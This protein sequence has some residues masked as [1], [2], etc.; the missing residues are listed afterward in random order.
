MAVELR[1][2]TLGV[3]DGNDDLLA[4]TPGSECAAEIAPAAVVLF[5]RLRERVRGSDG[6]RIFFLAV[7]VEKYGQGH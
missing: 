4:L 6:V 5:A 1:L 2:R 7:G 3:G